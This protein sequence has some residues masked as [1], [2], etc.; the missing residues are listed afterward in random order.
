MAQEPATSVGGV[1]ITLET[2]GCKNMG[3]ALLGRP[4][5]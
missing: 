2:G 4:G 1:K 3:T 5:M